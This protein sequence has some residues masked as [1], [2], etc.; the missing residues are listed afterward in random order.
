MRCF[1]NCDVH[2][3]AGSTPPHGELANVHLRSWSFNHTIQQISLSANR[4]EGK[5]P[6]QVMQLPELQKIRIDRNFFSCKV[7]NKTQ[8]YQ[9]VLKLIKKNP[10]KKTMERYHHKSL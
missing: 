6:E 7:W 5:V 4:L 8:V 2:I 9:Q 3:A 1:A 10:L